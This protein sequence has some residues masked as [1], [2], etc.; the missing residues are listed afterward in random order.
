MP[1]RVDPL[2]IELEQ[3]SSVKEKM[4]KSYHDCIQKINIGCEKEIAEAIAEIRLKYHNKRQEADATFNSR[5]KEVES[6]MYIVVINQV[7]AAT[8]RQKCQDVSSGCVAL[9]QGV[10]F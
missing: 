4:I 2:H 5:K 6:N 10:L 7:L 8:F 9:Q 1:H 3:L